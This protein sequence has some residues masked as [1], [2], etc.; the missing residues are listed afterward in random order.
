MMTPEE[1][2]KAL[3]DRRLAVVSRETGIHYNTLRS[4][5]DGDNKNPSYRVA[6][7]LSDYLERRP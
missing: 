5:R 3:E 1:M 6:K 2:Q 4:I 7:L